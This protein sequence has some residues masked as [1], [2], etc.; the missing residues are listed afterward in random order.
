M[1]P[2]LATCRDLRDAGIAFSV[3]YPGDSKSKTSKFVVFTIKE[4]LT[5]DQLSDVVDLGG[6][7]EKDG[8]VRILCPA[9]DE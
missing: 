4:S 2:F 1:E 6:M 8:V 9:R 5:T 3:H 7:L